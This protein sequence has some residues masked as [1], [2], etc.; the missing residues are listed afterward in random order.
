[1]LIFNLQSI[2][3][4]EPN[5]RLRQAEAA[6]F[7]DLISDWNE[8]TNLPIKL[9]EKLNEEYPLHIPA[10][11]F[12]SGDKQTVKAAVKLADGLTIETVLLREK[13]GRNTICVSS[14]VGCALGCAF[15]ATGALG[16]KRN[17]TTEEIINQVLLFAR[18]L[19]KEDDKIT[20]IVFMGMGEPF[21]NYESVLAA[22]KKLNDKDG[23]NLGA[24]R[25]SIS[26]AGIIPGIQ[27]FASEALEINLAVSLNAA[28]E[29]KRSQLM[30]SNDQYPLERLFKAVDNYILKTHRKVFFEY[31]LL[32]GVNDS[33]ADARSLARLMKKP[34]YHV[35]LI[36]YNE[37]GKF[38]PSDRETVRNFFNELE[39]SGVSVTLRRSFG[40]DIAAACGQLAGKG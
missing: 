2:L 22:I 36:N 1:M 5:Y 4:A 9:R 18:I 25:F 21:L 34:L 12:C 38:K 37:T 6:I 17:L 3:Q 16:F 30:P 28:S 8:A 10:Q 19:K 32:R 20:N 14:A 24:R 35:N 15:C 31:L 11:L 29:E 27:K 40:S 23:M 33:F 26:T 39:Q 13:K 7:V